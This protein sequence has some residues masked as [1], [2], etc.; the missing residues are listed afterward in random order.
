MAMEISTR[1]FVRQDV[2]IGPFVIDENLPFLLEPFPDLLR[3]Q[4]LTDQSLD[5]SSGRLINRRLSSVTSGHRQLMGLIRT[6]AFQAPISTQLSI[7]RRLM[8]AN[9]FCYRVLSMTHFHKGINLISVFLGK[10]FVIHYH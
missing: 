10:L 8:N 7:D 4:V 3:A 9:H 1:S 2:L 6:I 5:Q